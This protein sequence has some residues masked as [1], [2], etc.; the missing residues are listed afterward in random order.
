ML[1]MTFFFFFKRIVHPQLEFS[2]MFSSALCQFEL[3]T[4]EFHRWKEFHLLP[5]KWK[6]VVAM[7][8]N[9]K[10]TTQKNPQHVS[11]LLI[12]CHPSVRKIRQFND[13]VISQNMHY[14]HVHVS[15]KATQLP[16][17][18]CFWKLLHTGHG[19]G[20]PQMKTDCLCKFIRNAA[21]HNF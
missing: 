11:S 12:R 15:K 4:P 10:I 3:W 19:Y 5:V 16:I 9:L 14:S 7:Y 6:P 2:P 13:P 8:L 20:L 21:V 17:F 18:T 1:A